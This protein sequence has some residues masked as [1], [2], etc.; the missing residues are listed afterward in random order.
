[1]K[2]WAGTVRRVGVAV[3]LLGGLILGAAV[4]SIATAGS[5]AAQQI[6]VQGNRRVEA[7][8]IQSYFRL[9]PG[10]RLDDIKI[11]SAYKALI[12][13][14]L[15]QDVQ[16]RRA[17]NQIVVTVVEAPVINRVQFEGNRRV[18]DDVLTSELRSNPA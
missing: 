8:T 2:L 1:M 18:K 17:G 5:A 3:L 6:V 14:G 16:V 7:S 4:T 13:T 11:D 15:F 12:N 9:G 10:E